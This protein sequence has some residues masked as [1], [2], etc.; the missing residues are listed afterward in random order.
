[1]HSIVCP[2][3]VRIAYHHEGSG[4]DVVVL[5]HGFTGTGKAHFA[6]EIPFLAPHMQI[7]APDLRGYGASAPPQRVFGVD[8]YQNDAADMIAFITALNVGPVHLVG[9]SDG[10][11]IALYIAAT[12]PHLVRSALVWGVCGQITPEMVEMVHKWR[13]LSTWDERY[14]AWKAEIIALHGE[15]QFEPMVEGWILA[16]DAILARGGDVLFGVAAQIE[17]PIMIVH[18]SEDTGN[19]IPMVTALANK[20]KRCQ[21]LLLDG[22]GH[23]VQDEAPRELH[24]IMAEWYGFNEAV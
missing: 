10:A 16:A 1:M 18:G 11:E 6:K 5:L 9:F 22:I 24:Q 23:D 17:A 15:A 14:P 4:D 3:G 13:P 12:A 2:N 19:P 20:I 7:Y 21:F 8:F